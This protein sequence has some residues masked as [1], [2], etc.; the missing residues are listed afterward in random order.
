MSK[1]RDSAYYKRQLERRF[2]KL[3]ADLTSG[4]IGSVRQAAGAAGLIHLPTRL[5]ALKREWKKAGKSD[6]RAFVVWLRGTIVSPPAVRPI[7]RSIIDPGGHLRPAVV[8]FISDW[9]VAQR[10]TP[11]KIMKEIGFK[12]YDATLALALK[13]GKPIRSEVLIPLEGWLARNGFRAW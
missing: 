12:N 13:R 5:D 6:R 11:G 7:K 9:T 3:F 4:K 2:P 10:I 8:K 1:K